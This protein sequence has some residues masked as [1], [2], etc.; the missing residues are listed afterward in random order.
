MITSST[1]TKESYESYKL[2]LAISQHFK[3]PSYDFFYYNG[4]VNCS[5]SSFEK[6]NDIMYFRRLSREKNQIN[7]LVSHMA[8]SSDF[9]IREIVSKEGEEKQ[10][11][12]ENQF[13][14]FRYRFSSE[15]SSLNDEVKSN[16]EVN[17]S[18]ELPFAIQMFYRREISLETLSVLSKKMKLH[19][20]WISTHLKKHVLA[21]DLINRVN[22]YYEFFRK[23]I[24]E[25][26]AEETIRNRWNL[27]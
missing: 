24:D 11:K 13:N 21:K 27:Y 26:S 15:L 20:Y 9:H 14:S 1:P 2:Y 5:E 23:K 6:R 12:W 8:F 4:K 17:N 16:F 18:N 3:T 25:K 19:E 7:R 22:K 10:R